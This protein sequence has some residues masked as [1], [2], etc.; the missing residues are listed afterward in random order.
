[1]SVKVAQNAQKQLSTLMVTVF[2]MDN[3]PATSLVTSAGTYG[4]PREFCEVVIP[5]HSQASLI[6][7]DFLSTN[8]STISLPTAGFGDLQAGVPAGFS[9]P[10]T[11]PIQIPLPELVN[12]ARAALTFL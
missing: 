1:M 5:C 10:T 8:I 11:G 9:L 3:N 7:Q 12:K 4:T 2:W 6:F